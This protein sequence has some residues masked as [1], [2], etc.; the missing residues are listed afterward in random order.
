[1][2]IHRRNAFFEC[3]KPLVPL[4]GAVI[5]VIAASF[6][7]CVRHSPPLYIP[8]EVPKPVEVVEKKKE[9]I[10]SLCPVQCPTARISSCFGERRGKDRVHKG[11]DISVQHGTPVVAAAEGTTSFCGI[12]SKY[13]KMVIIDHCNG[14]E[15]VYAHLDKILTAQG[16]S[17]KRGTQIGLVGA[18]GNAT[19][20]HL[21]YEVRKDGDRVNPESFFP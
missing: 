2:M 14:Y 11:V 15:T 19:G 4:M 6:T 9:D 5:I 18:T 7:G 17:V 12:Q 20:S 3:A 8:P 21:H 13:G 16:V 10:P 1:M